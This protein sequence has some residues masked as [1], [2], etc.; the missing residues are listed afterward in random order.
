MKPSNKRRRSTES[1]ELQAPDLDRKR[2]KSVSGR[3]RE[4]SLL[5]KI[6]YKASKSKKLWKERTEYGAE[7]ILI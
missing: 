6:G 2:H 3:R 4:A 1:K 7:Y 5:E